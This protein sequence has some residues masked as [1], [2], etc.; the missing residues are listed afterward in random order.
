[1]YDLRFTI[2]A[3][4]EIFS[5]L[6]NRISYIV[7]STTASEDFL[8][9]RLRRI[10]PPQRLRRRRHLRQFLRAQQLLER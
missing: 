8:A 10:R 1:M 6:V 3:P 9:N 2:D 4:L 7:N 5:T